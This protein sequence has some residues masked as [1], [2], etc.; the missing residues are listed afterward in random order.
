MPDGIL[1]LDK[2]AGISSAYAVT[3]IKRMLPRGTKVGHAGTL[4][5]FATG[6]LLVLV[7]KATKRCE[8][9]MGQP[10][11]Y[12]STIKLGVTTETLDPTSPEI[13]EPD[14]PVPGQCDIA[15][16]LPRFIGTIQQVPPAYSALWRDGKRAYDLARAGKPVELEPR[17]VTIYAIDLLLYSYPML[18]LDIQCGRGTYIRSL[19]RDIAAAL[20]T[21]GHLASLR[22]TAVGP[23]T[24]DRATT[25]ASLTAES[26]AAAILP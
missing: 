12:L 5:P 25:L 21:I 7:G 19:A 11:R 6:V 9:L 22:R 14:P 20:G 23:Y 10:K 17:P 4:D 3:R 8:E 26:V 13:T 2:P 1:V 24:V 16:I 18:E 15:A